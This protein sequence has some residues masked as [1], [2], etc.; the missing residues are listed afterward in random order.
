MIRHASV[1]DKAA[2][3]DIAVDSGLFPAEHV[4]ELSEMMDAQLGA[5]SEG[6]H[7]IVQESERGTL[8]G[9]AY[10]APEALTD[11]TFNL[12]FIAVREILKGK[13]V[14]SA[15]LHYVEHQLKQEQGRV[16]IIE[17]SSLDNYNLTRRF[18]LKHEYTEVARIPEF[19]SAGEDKVVFWRKLKA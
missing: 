17:T 6:H 19:F 18:Y 13:G 9:A 14:G 4:G 8:Q 11:G 15:L 1:A 2:I 16:L 3:L 7:W 10:Y 12:Y 5:T